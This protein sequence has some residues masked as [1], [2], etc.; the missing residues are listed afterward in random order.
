VFESSSTT[1]GRVD[2]H[3]GDQLPLG[4]RGLEEFTRGQGAPSLEASFVEET[5][6]FFPI[7]DDS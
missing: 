6:D 5:E 4:D 1:G 7:E 2:F 3:R